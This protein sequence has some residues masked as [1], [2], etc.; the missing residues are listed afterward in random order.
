MRNK[1]RPFA[2][3]CQLMNTLC[4][5]KNTHLNRFCFLALSLTKYCMKFSLQSVDTCN[6]Q[7]STDW[8]ENFIQ[9]NLKTS[10]TVHNWCVLLNDNVLT[11]YSSMEH[12]TWKSPGLMCGWVGRI[13]NPNSCVSVSSWSKVPLLSIWSVAVPLCWPLLACSSRWH[14]FLPRHGLWWLTKRCH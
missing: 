14:G 1:L 6:L 7:V 8:S 2:V 9:Y 5:E 11:V 13:L 10:Y 4:S 3:Y 12:V